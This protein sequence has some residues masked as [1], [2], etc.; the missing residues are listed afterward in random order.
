MSKYQ[1]VEEVLPGS[2]LMDCSRRVPRTHPLTKAKLSP[3]AL[4]VCSWPHGNTERDVLD[5]EMEISGPYKSIE[6]V[7]AKFP[8]AAMDEESLKEALSRKNWSPPEDAI[9]AR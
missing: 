1:R 4:F 6:R 5:R 8:N 2:Y 9:N 3:M 7:K